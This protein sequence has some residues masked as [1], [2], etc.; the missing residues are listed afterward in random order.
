MA[1]PQSPITITLLHSFGELI[2]PKYIDI[3]RQPAGATHRPEMHHSMATAG[4]FEQVKA[5]RSG[6]AA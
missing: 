1:E 6:T 2:D 5:E 3:N 4:P